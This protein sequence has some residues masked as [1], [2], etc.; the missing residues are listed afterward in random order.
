MSAVA[1][2]HES[3]AGHWE[4]VSRSPHPAL[5]D[6]VRRYC[7]YTERMTAPQRRREVISGD[8]VLIVAFGPAMRLRYPLAPGAPEERRTSFVVG[9]HAPVTVTEHDGV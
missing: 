7:G 1:L 5:R 2:R 6:H 9:L 4:V 3:P 8:V